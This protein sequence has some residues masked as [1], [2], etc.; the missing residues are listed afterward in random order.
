[1]F[2]HLY[3]LFEVMQAQLSLL[4]YKPSNTYYAYAKELFSYAPLL[5][6]YGVLS[7]C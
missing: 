4:Y 1:M 2:A 3:Y 6:I 7:R 5:G